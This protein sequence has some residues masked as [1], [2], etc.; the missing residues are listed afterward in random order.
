M[1]MRIFVSA[2]LLILSFSPAAAQD[3][4]TYDYVPPQDFG[5]IVLAGQ[6]FVSE[7]QLDRP[8]EIR[9]RLISRGDLGSHPC[10]R[11][12]YT[13]PYETVGTS[14]NREVWL[15]CIPVDEIL[16]DSFHCAGSFFPQLFGS[17]NDQKIRHCSLLDPRDVEPTFIPV[18]IPAPLRAP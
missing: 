13:Y 16:K 18:C 10:L 1:G 2:A 7:I 4:T 14:G 8:L 3:Q 11:G 5:F 9:P 6:V 15:C 12:S 17:S